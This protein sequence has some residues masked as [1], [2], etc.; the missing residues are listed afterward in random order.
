MCSSY[1]PC[2]CIQEILPLQ[3][4]SF[5]LSKSQTRVRINR[6]MTTQYSNCKVKRTQHSTGTVFR[7]QRQINLVHLLSMTSCHTTHSPGAVRGGGQKFVWKFLARTSA[8]IISTVF[9]V[10]VKQCS[11]TRRCSATVLVLHTIV[12][13]VVTCHSTHLNINTVTY[14]RINGFFCR[15]RVKRLVFQR[16]GALISF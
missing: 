7:V 3:H 14:F 15:Q 8:G 13:V 5:C 11:D 9:V 12:W 10:L 2:K 1:L 6:G 4:E 16:P